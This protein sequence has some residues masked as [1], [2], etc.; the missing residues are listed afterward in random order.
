VLLTPCA[1]AAEEAVGASYLDLRERC[2]TT[3]PVIVSEGVVLITSSG[4]FVLSATLLDSNLL[5]AAPEAGILI[6]LPEVDTFTVFRGTGV[7]TTPSE[8]ITSG[9]PLEAGVPLDA[10]V[11]A[12]PPEAGVPT[13]ILDAFLE[14]GVCT[15]SLDAGVV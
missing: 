14:L 6:T 10:A 7:L 13:T 12:T 5:A 15:T 8:T 1:L 9:D 4:V 11:E 3:A 2:F